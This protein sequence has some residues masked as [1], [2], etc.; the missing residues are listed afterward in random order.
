MSSTH[1]SM[2]VVSI[3]IKNKIVKGENIEREIFCLEPLK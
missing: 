1:R 2:I 3:V